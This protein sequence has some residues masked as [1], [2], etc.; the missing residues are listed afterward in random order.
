M[1]PTNPDD[2]R[3]RPASRPIV[4]S[5][6]TGPT[7]PDMD[8]ARAE[9]IK[10]HEKELADAERL[11]TQA[12]SGTAPL[13]PASK[14]EPRQVERGE[15]FVEF[16]W[17]GE[18][19]TYFEHDRSVVMS[20]TFWGGPKGNV[21]HMFASWEYRDGHRA[22]MSIDERK[23]VLRRV[24]ERASQLHGITLEPIGD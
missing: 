19:A 20:C 18:T 4:F 22:P 7:A 21:A 12:R 3:P 13:P 15:Y 1:N 23:D 9:G 10:R 11:T 14:S 8:Q 17:R 2:S 6:V 16:D 5:S 24:V